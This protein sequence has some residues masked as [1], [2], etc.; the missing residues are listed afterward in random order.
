[1]KAIYSCHGV[2]TRQHNEPAGN[3]GVWHYHLHVTPRY[4]GDGFY[5]TLTS[6]RQQMAIG[7]RAEHA[8]RL[9][10]HLLISH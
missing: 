10:E 2:S 3:Q 5:N 1:M 8:K 7:E 9:K 4:N 6:L